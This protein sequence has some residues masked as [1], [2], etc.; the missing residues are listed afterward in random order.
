MPIPATVVTQIRNGALRPYLNMDVAKIERSILRNCSNGR[1]YIDELPNGVY[2]NMFGEAED[3][4]DRLIALDLLA[5]YGL[6]NPFSERPIQ[7]PGNPTPTIQNT[8]TPQEILDLC[9]HSPNP[10]LVAFLY[11]QLSFVVRNKAMMLDLLSE[12]CMS[13]Y[14]RNQATTQLFFQICLNPF[15]Q[16]SEQTLAAFIAKQRELANPEPSDLV[17]NSMFPAT[18]P[19]TSTTTNPTATTKHSVDGP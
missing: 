16:N 19:H 17:S 3:H 11:R 14:L 2:V 12:Q 4:K 7:Q 8:L 9:N 10:L 15:N 5:Q 13:V 18:T 6:L 1:R